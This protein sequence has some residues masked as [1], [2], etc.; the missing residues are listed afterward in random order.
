MK[1]LL[2]V[3]HLYLLSKML[4]D[5]HVLLLIFQLLMFGSSLWFSIA[6]YLLSGLFLIWFL[7]SPCLPLISFQEK[8]DFI[9]LSSGFHLLLVSKKWQNYYFASSFGP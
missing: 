4:L 1:L 8:K 9:H 6:F 7:F 5:L 2:F 3:L